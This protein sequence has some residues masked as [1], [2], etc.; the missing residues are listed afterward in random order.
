MAEFGK[1]IVIGLGFYSYKEKKIHI[2][3]IVN[4]SD[5]EKKLLLECK[6]QLED[7][8]QYM[9]KSNK[10]PFLLCGHNSIEFDFPYICRRFLVNEI[11]LPSCFDIQ[12]LKPWDLDR[13]LD[14]MEMWK[15]GDKKNHISLDLLACIFDLESS[16]KSLDGSQ[17]QTIYYSESED[18]FKRLA[19]YCKG[20]VLLTAQVYHKLLCKSIVLEETDRI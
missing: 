3:S 9:K 13:Y 16:K 6:N 19:D 20:D 12:T 5:D 1:I 11:S 18:R 2:K 15:F 7:L 4:Q 8:E 10:L 17:I 14:T